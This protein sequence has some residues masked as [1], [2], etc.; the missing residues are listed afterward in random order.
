MNIQKPN[1]L[2]FKMLMQSYGCSWS[3]LCSTSLRA[4]FPCWT[5]SPS[6]HHEIP[7]MYVLPFPGDAT[8]TFGEMDIQ[9]EITVSAGK[10]RIGHPFECPPNS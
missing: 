4:G 1:G 3:I 7:M 10:G 5:T 9:Q 6:M 8:P 2:V